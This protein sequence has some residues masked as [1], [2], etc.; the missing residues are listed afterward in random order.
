MGELMAELKIDQVR[1]QLDRRMTELQRAQKQLQRPSTLSFVERRSL[2]GRAEKTLAELKE[3]RAALEGKA[4]GDDGVA[5]RLTQIEEILGRAEAVLNSAGGHA[6]G[7]K[8]SPGGDRRIPG[9][10]T[11]GATG[12]SQQRPPDR[13]GGE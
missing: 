7:S 3:Q 8:H 11:R 1:E 6:G 5:E 13:K 9:Q 10:A 2:S 4:D 12:A